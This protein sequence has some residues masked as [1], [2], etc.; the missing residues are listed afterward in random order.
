MAPALLAIYARA[1]IYLSPL[2]VPVCKY[3]PAPHVAGLAHLLSWCPPGSLVTWSAS[4]RP[5]LLTFAAASPLFPGSAGVLGTRP[6]RPADCGRARR[7]TAAPQPPPPHPRAEASATRGTRRARPGPLA[8]R[9]SAP[10]PAPAR[11]PGGS[12]LLPPSASLERPGP[13]S[14]PWKP[15]LLRVV[16]CMRFSLPCGV[17]SLLNVGKWSPRAAVALGRWPL[18]QH[19]GGWGAGGLCRSWTLFREEGRLLAGFL[20]I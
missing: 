13:V 18:G 3:A 11:G 17:F 4:A 8:L 14:P 9:P 5:G 2:A 12:A 20:R 19:G 7:P 15:S 16:V 10:C 1:P 6:E